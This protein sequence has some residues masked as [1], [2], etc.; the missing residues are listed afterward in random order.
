LT[1]L[2]NYY[3]DLFLATVAYKPAII[4]QH[5]SFICLGSLPFIRSALWSHRG[6]THW[7]MDCCSEAFSLECV[8]G[9]IFGFLHPEVT[10]KS[11]SQQN[12]E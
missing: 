6:V 12:D 3:G 7:F 4:D 11:E 2:L 1:Y 9:A 10:Q 8:V 5:K